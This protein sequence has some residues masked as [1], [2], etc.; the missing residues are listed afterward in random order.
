MRTAP[1]QADRHSAKARAPHQA[2]RVLANR[3]VNRMS[4]MAVP[5]LH[6]AMFSPGTPMST[7]AAGLR[8][9]QRRLAR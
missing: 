2:E 9:A 6:R 8:W 5:A 7:R 4:I 3:V 1:D